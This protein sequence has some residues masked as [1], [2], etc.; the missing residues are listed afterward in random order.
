MAPLFSFCSVFGDVAASRSGVPGSA[1]P[2]GPRRSPPTFIPRIKTLSHASCACRQALGRPSRAACAV[3]AQPDAKRPRRGHSPARPVLSAAGGRPGEPAP[4]RRAL[5]CPCRPCRPCHH[6][7]SWSWSPCRLQCRRP[8]ACSCCR[9][10]RC[11]PSR[12]LRCCSRNARIWACRCLD[13][14]RRRSCQVCNN[15]QRHRRSYTGRCCLAGRNTGSRFARR[16]KL[17]LLRYCTGHS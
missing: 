15:Q 5:T 10:C 3:P 9:S 8:G 14:C 6:R 11:P 12:N 2:P 13:P 7:W 1:C 16:H 17:G 4:P